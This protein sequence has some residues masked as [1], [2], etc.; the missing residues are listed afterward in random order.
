MTKNPAPTEVSRLTN[1]GIRKRKAREVIASM[2]GG[3]STVSTTSLPILPG[4][5]GWFSFLPFSRLLLAL[6]KLKQPVS[7]LSLL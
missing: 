1:S 6:Q 5:S 2:T 4:A 7:E 3:S